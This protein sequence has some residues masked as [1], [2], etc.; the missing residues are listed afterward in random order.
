MTALPE[1]VEDAQ[2]EGARMLTLVAPDHIEADEN[3]KVAALWVQPQIISRIGD[4]GRTGVRKADKPLQRIPCD[5][6]VVAIGQAIH[7]APLEPA[8]IS[9]KWGM[10]IAE[11]SSFVPGSGNLFAGGD[12]VSGPATV[13][14][15]IA[16]G[17]VAAANIDDFFGFNH[18]IKVDVDI[19]REPVS[20][21]PPCGRVQL[22]SRGIEDIEGDFDIVQEGMSKEE[23]L[24]ECTRCLRCDKFGFGAFRE[25]R[26]TQW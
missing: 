14:R 23:C 18:I 6:V 5:I 16:A 20:S 11:R 3:G 12:A 21:T 22:A 13:I 9:T 4:D 25:G 26:K 7:A 8:G 10:I 2:A 24:Q 17:K 15:A 19:P 1:E